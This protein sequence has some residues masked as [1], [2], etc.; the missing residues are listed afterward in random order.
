MIRIR[1]APTG[2]VRWA[3]PVRIVSAF[4]PGV[5]DAADG[6]AG[7][8]R[9]QL[10]R[11]Q[12]SVLP[13]SQLWRLSVAEAEDWHVQLKGLAWKVVTR[14]A[15]WHGPDREE[16]RPWCS[17]GPWLQCTGRSRPFA[18][19]PALRRAWGGGAAALL[20]HQLSSCANQV[21]PA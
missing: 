7:A 11:L 9:P 15:C 19:L 16:N 18:T 4:K 21:V 6:K 1:L 17:V 3:R 10:P 5:L 8:P 2:E 20:P 14:K 12:C 13:G